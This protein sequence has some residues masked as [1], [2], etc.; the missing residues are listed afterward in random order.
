MEQE[1]LEEL[2]PKAVVGQQLTLVTFVAEGRQSVQYF[3]AARLISVDESLRS[4]DE[5]TNAGR[6]GYAVERIPLEQLAG[7]DLRPTVVRDFVLENRSA[8]LADPPPAG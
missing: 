1:L 7:C 3:F 6:D 4:G 8:V 2:G 5:Y